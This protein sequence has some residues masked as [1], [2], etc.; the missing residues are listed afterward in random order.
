MT[1]GISAPGSD[2][3][4]E[5]ARSLGWDPTADELE[6]YP[7]AIARFAESLDTVDELVEAEARPPRPGRAPSGWEPSDE[8]DP[9]HAWAWKSD[10]AGAESGPLTGK[11]AV[12]KDN[13][14]VA[15]LP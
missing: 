12:F 4:R 15:G 6:A 1:L 14:A 11:R 3:I 8:E 2:E 5:I 9:L 10:I 7:A 13:I